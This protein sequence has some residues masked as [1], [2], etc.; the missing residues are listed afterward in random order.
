MPPTNRNLWALRQPTRQAPAPANT[1][2]RT[3]RN[4]VLRY[5]ALTPKAADCNGTDL[6]NELKSIK[7][8]LST[9]YATDK[10]KNQWLQDAYDLRDKTTT[11]LLKRLAARHDVFKHASLANLGHA[12]QIEQIRGILTQLVRQIIPAYYTKYNPVLAPDEQARNALYEHLLHELEKFAVYGSN[13]NPLQGQQVNKLFHHMNFLTR[14]SRTPEYRQFM[15]VFQFGNSKYNK[16]TP[17]RSTTL[18]PDPRNANYPA[19]LK[20]WYSNFS[21]LQLYHNA[22]S[23]VADF[24][25]K[26]QK[27]QQKY[28]K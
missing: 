20:A 10:G 23:R 21:R 25:P 6:G 7:K 16:V 12:Q 1:R 8:R 27:Y 2:L 14:I 11:C 26:Q 19:L 22:N 3:L 24:K 5:D 28:K 4:T 18:L 9:N 13:F 15:Y 17:E